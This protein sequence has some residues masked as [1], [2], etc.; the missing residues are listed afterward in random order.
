MSLWESCGSYSTPSLYGKRRHPHQVEKKKR[1]EVG[2]KGVSPLAHQTQ[3]QPRR[4]AFNRTQ[5]LR[6]NTAKKIDVKANGL[7]SKQGHLRNS[8]INNSLINRKSTTELLSITLKSG[9]RGT[10]IPLIETSPKLG[11]RT[12][13]PLPCLQF[14]I[15]P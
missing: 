7:N 3:A 4:N 10:G 14:Y 2:H 8:P 9:L 6:E 5:L 15:N 13:T 11:A 1:A 12:T